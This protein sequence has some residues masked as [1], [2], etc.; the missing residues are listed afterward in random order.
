MA[1]GQIANLKGVQGDP[2]PTGGTGP[3]GD[4]G[5]PGPAGVDGKGIQI[6]GSVANYAA[7]PTD[8]TVGDAGKG[9]LNNANGQLYIWDGAAFPPESSGVA[10]KGDK[11]DTGAKG[12]PGDMGPAGPTGDTGPKGDPGNVG[13]NGVR[14][15]TW[16]TGNGGPPVEGIVG[17]QVGDLYLDRT[18][19]E[20]YLLS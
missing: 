6:A 3:K 1:W 20:V 15:N 7:L 2:G 17:S 5:D 18:S 14:G 13:P 16:Y 10:F 8:L 12:D 9:Y 11:G 19:G 4:Q